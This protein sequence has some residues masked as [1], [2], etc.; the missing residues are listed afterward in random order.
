[1]NLLFTFKKHAWEETKHLVE[2]TYIAA[3]FGNNMTITDEE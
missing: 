3:M 1:V 2:I